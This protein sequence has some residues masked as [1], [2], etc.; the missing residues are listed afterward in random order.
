M[1]KGRITMAHGGGGELTNELIKEI[2][3]SRLSNNYLSSLTDS[4][5]LGK[6]DGE[7]CFTTDSYVVRPL[8]F[9]GGDIGNLAVCGTVNDLAV[10]GAKPLALSLGLIIEE[11]FEIERLARIIDS[12]ASSAKKAGVSIVTGDTKV[13]ENTKGE[14]LFINT[15]GVGE[16]DDSINIDSS[17]ISEGDAIIVTGNIADHGLAIMCCR[18]GLSL[19]TQ[20]KSD[21]APLNG[22]LNKITA[23]GAAVHFIRD[24]TRAGVAGVLADINEY[25]SLGIIVEEE[26]LPITHSARHAAELLGLDPLIVANEGKCVIVAGKN[27]AQKVVDICRSDQF[28][29]DAR[30]IG[31]MT[32]LNNNVELHTAIGGKRLIYRPYGEQLPRIC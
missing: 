6:V 4:A 23:S 17:N 24:A 21:V 8:E 13:I 20:L 28:G 3:V 19:Q 29:K 7:I 25:T 32:A 27:D 12:I 15:A 5:I 31:Y 18:E 26:S 11:G 2:I 30:I 9:P 16:L 10:M 14:G 22:L 1:N